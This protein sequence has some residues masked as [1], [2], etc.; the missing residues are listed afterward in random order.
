MLKFCS[1]LAFTRRIGTKRQPVSM[2]CGFKYKLVGGRSLRNDVIIVSYDVIVFY[3]DIFKFDVLLLIK[4][5]YIYS[6][7]VK[8]KY[9]R[10]IL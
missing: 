6:I 3:N 4:K 5:I 8:R 2:E 7:I 1:V 9:L 10:T